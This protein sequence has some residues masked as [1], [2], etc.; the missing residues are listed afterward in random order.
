LGESG[1][2][3]ALQGDLGKVIPKP[4]H[5]GMKFGF[6]LVDFE[7]ALRNIGLDGRLL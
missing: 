1:G 6:H 4:Q 7:W 3:E 5:T 2:L